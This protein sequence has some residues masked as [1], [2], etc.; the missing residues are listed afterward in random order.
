MPKNE[1]NSAR[2]GHIDYNINLG[3]LRMCAFF[4]NDMAKILDFIL[5]ELALVHSRWK[6]YSLSFTR[7][8]SRLAKCSFSVL[9]VTMMSSR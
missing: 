8:D 3:W 1:R 2:K 5:E 4:V 7:V 9:P 6:P